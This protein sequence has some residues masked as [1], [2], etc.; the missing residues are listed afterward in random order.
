MKRFGDGDGVAGL[1]VWNQTEYCRLPNTLKAVRDVHLYVYSV[2]S[3]CRMPWG[4]LFNSIPNI[5]KTGTMSSFVRVAYFPDKRFPESGDNSEGKV[6]IQ[7]IIYEIQQIVLFIC[8]SLLFDRI[9][10]GDK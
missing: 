4:K 1:F 10:I 6:V 7:C 3:L 8:F 5:M 9:F 2:C